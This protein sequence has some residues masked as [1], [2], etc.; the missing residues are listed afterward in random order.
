MPNPQWFDRQIETYDLSKLYNSVLSGDE[1]GMQ[2]LLKEYL[3]K[4]ISYY[5]NKEAFYHG[6]MVGLLG[7]VPGY[8][9]KSNREY[10]NG[11]PD[12]VLVPTDEE[13]TV[14]VLELKH[15]SKFRELEAGCNEAVKQIEEQEYFAPFIDEGY[16][17]MMGYGICFCKKTCMVKKFDMV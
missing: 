10:G 17:K 3:Q 16:M 13:K 5:D 11:R 4:S 6:V 1:S 2:K 15:C 9:I 7:S 8:V 14:I 12:I